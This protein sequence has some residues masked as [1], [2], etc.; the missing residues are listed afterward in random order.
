[1]PCLGVGIVL[2]WSIIFYIVVS[3]VIDQVRDGSTVRVELLLNPATFE[4]AVIVLH[5]A[6]VQCPRVPL[7]LAVLQ[8]QQ[9]ALLAD[10]PSARVEPVAFTLAIFCLISSNSI[11]FFLF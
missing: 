10:D 4:H 11:I 7:P 8:A 1:M 3:G 2:K 6:G 9:A 5:L